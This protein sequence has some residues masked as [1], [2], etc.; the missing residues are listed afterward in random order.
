MKI[1][2]SYNSARQKYGDEIVKSLSKT[3]VP[4]KYLLSAC[5]YYQEKHVPI[6]RIQQLFRQWMTYVVRNNA[7]IDVNNL[8]FEE[9]YQTIQKYKTEYGIANK[10]YS[11][12]HVSIGKINSA[13]D[14]GRFPVKN[15]WCIKQSGKF[16]KYINNGYSFY[17]ID[18]GDASDYI[19]YAILMVSKDGRK[20]Y[21]DLDNEEMTPN[22][23]SAYLAHLTKG[24]LSFIQDL[25]KNEQ[26]CSKT[27]KEQTIRLTESEFKNIITEAVRRYIQL[28]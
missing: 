9:F 26:Y 19:R 13:K 18:N 11:D 14:I 21:Y 2:E 3:G 22:S 23:I 7:D 8:S 10:V 6:E 4:P 25:N 16:Q 28:L 5:R 24:A 27:H 12:D 1:F 17:I 20:F 15:S